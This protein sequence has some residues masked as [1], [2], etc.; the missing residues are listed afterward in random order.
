MPLSTA[1]ILTRCMNSLRLPE[2]NTTQQ[3]RVLDI[4]NEVYRDI[5][6]K[7]TWY[8]LVKRQVFNTT[9][10]VTTGTIDVASGNAQATLSASPGVVLT[11]R[12]LVIP[13]NASDSATYRVSDSMATFSTL[14][15][16]AAYTGQTEASASYRLYT[17]EYSLATDSGRVLFVKRFGFTQKLEI[18]NPEEMQTVKGFDVSEGPPQSAALWEFETTGDPTTPRRITLWPYPDQAYRVEVW[19]KQRGNAE[20][21]GTA[22]PLIP[23]EYAQVLVY[24]TLSRAYPILLNDTERGTY[25]LQLFNDV[26]NLMVA[27][28]RE[29][30]G[31]PS[32]VPRDTHRQF[33]TRTTR[34]TAANSDLG[35]MFDR[36]PFNPAWVLWLVL[37]LPGA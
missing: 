34:R 2:S 11:G 21:S 36:F 15:L 19:Y 37:G 12:K 9:A 29:Y 35:S 25:Y 30:E 27:Q 33:Y 23:D 22:R 6:A 26:L 17:D 28:Q 31:H 16:D 18:L 3:T 14:S 24:G 4:L 20:L 7:Y 10:K 13:S 1:Q 8:W 5:L 32:F